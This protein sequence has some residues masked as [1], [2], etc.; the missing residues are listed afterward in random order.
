MA[1]AKP[2]PGGPHDSVVHKIGGG[3]VVHLWQ[4]VRVWSRYNDDTGWIAPRLMKGSKRIP[5]RYFV[6][7]IS[8]QYTAR[9]CFDT[10]IFVICL[11]SSVGIGR[12]S[13]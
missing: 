2:H 5:A 9:S 10:F 13:R 4:D 7:L 3:N 8:S 12:V 11:F 6:D 1:L